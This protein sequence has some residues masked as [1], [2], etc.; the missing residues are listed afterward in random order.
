MRGTLFVDRTTG[1]VLPASDAMVDDSSSGASRDSGD[2]AL[3]LEVASGDFRLNLYFST[4]GCEVFAS[5]AV[6]GHPPVA[7]WFEVDGVS[8]R[9]PCDRSGF[10]FMSWS[11]PPAVLSIALESAVEQRSVGTFEFLT[12]DDALPIVVRAHH[13][14]WE[15][16]VPAL[17]PD[18]IP[19][20]GSADDLI[21]ALLSHAGGATEAAA[22][23]GGVVTSNDLL[24]K[25][26]RMDAEVVRG[27]G[28]GSHVLVTRPG[29]ARPVPIP[30]HPGD[31]GKGLYKK[32]VKDLGLLLAEVEAA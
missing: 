13:S 30:M 23:R 7:V 16:C 22:T 3:S 12:S 31:L 27:R 26:L 11:N 17:R 1:R 5:L 2:E 10:S 24:R 18:W 4:D 21:A 14:G 25:L 20:D 29:L 19:F 6:E 9:V 8:T 15:L 28:K 32:I